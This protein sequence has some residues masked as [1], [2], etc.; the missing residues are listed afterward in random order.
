MNILV[1]LDNY[2][3]KKKIDD[4]YKDYVYGYDITFKEDVIDYLKKEKK[5]YT[6]VTKLG[7]KGNIT[8]EEYIENIRL[9]NQKN[10]IVIITNFLSTNEKKMLFSNEVFNIIVGNEID[11]DSI[12]NQIETK[13]KIIYKTL[14]KKDLN[15][16]NVRKIAV[17][18]TSGAGKSFISYL[19]SKSI[20][21]YTDSN[22]ILISLDY[23]NPCVDVLLNNPAIKYDINE[24]VQQV[25]KDG[26]EKYITLDKNFK[27]LS[28][29]NPYINNG[30]LKG[31][32]VAINSCLNIDIK[33]LIGNLSK[34][35]ELIIFDMPANTLYID[36]KD[37][38]NFVDDVL[39]VLNPN[40]IC[41]KQA[42]KY[43]QYIQ[44][45]IPN[46]MKKITIISN[47][48]SGYS[49]DISQI[50]SILK[51]KS[52]IIT[53]KYYQMMEGY[54]NGILSN[55]KFLTKDEIELLKNLKIKIN[56]RSNRLNIIERWNKYGQFDKFR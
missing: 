5:P 13:D 16:K 46:L 25:N 30:I 26:I 6:I 34:S 35:Y 43:I 39:F 31:K 51:T 22:V 1:A 8:D 47:K 17:F 3:I 24:F 49:L 40:Y 36:L 45:N 18:G 42:K 21:S 53:V 9:T 48:S 41:L 2:D 54:I 20:A 19:L 11:I 28:Y 10:K 38:L 12:Y 50:K 4:K 37:V 7:L 44:E 52:Y 33:K 14:Y 15:N 56:K 27:N 32:K 23:L 29:I 55:S